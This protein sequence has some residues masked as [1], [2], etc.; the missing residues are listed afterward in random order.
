M[1]SSG[2]MRTD[3]E[4]AL[5]AAAA[6]HARLGSDRVTV[7]D[8]RA[9]DVWLDAAPE[10]QSAWT[11]TQ[12]AWALMGQL[13]DHPAMQKA[14]RGARRP[15]LSR[16]WAPAAIAASLLIAVGAGSMAWRSFSPAQPVAG[17]SS[18]AKIERYAT[19]V[20]EVRRIALSDGTAVVLD[21]DS[22]LDVNFDGK[23]RNIALTRGRAHFQVA[24][25]PVHPFVVTAQGRSVTALGTVF[26]VDL[27]RA[28]VTVTLLQGK[29][30][31]RDLAT[32][33]GARV[34]TLT[35]G[36]RL[37]ATDR[38]AWSRK[39]VDT[40]QAV[41][42][43]SGDLVFDD[44]P[45]GS[46]AAELN[47]YSRRKLVVADAAL[48]RAPIS[49]VFRAGDPEALVAGLQASGVARVSRRSAEAI[50]LANP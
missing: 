38:G 44:R 42:W 26:D 23:V 20:G 32:G 6:W 8:H 19:A 49:G 39:A 17:A 14:R 37:V 36:D 10:N 11:R 25:D 22:A 48:A 1:T 50:E 27:E 2:T 4:L 28:A 24:H 35:P 3:D 7:E 18:S 46:V 13:A 30:A 12:Q 47:R 33:E 21:A 9:F 5:D 15:A 43:T 29:V 31:V 45:L 34:A 16:I 40:T 41:R